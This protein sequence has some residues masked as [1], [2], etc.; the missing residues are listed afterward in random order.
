MNNEVIL[1]IML[2]CFILIE[3]R[4]WK[5]VMAYCG[6]IKSLLIGDIVSPSDIIRLD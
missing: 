5:S 6:R 4:K 3:R 2:G 1:G